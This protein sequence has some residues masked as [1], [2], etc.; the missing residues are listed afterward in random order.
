LG[1]AMDGNE[2]KIFPV[3]EGKFGGPPLDWSQEYADIV[4]RI[5]PKAAISALKERAVSEN[6]SEEQR[7]QA[8]VALGFIYDQEAVN[9]MQE[10]MAS[11][12]SDVKDQALWWLRYRRDNEWGRFEM[13]IPELE[14]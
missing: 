1:L 13:E 3:L 12:I 7:K 2:E 14:A 4:W 9:A 6:L 5:H 10:V 8:M 11:G